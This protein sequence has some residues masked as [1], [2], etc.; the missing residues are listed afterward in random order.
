M[1]KMVF[2]NMKDLKKMIDLLDQN[3]FEYSWYFMNKIYEIHLG[4]TNPDHVKYMLK[5]GN[6]TIPFK[7]DNYYW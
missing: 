3:N 2:T 4:S 6:V 5:N 1:K 7:W